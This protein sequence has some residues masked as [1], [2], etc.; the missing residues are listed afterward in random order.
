M[1][2]SSLLMKNTKSI[3][4]YQSEILLKD[5]KVSYVVSI[6]RSDYTIT[7]KTTSSAGGSSLCTFPIASVY[8][9][10]ELCTSRYLIVITDANYVGE[11]M[12]KKISRSEKLNISPLQER[13]ISTI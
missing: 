13:L 12:G 9:I 11:I 2:D 3:E 10:I 7:K 1:V 8:G 5:E 6:S 4:I